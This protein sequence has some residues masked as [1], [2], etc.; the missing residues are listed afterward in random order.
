MIVM[1]VVAPETHSVSFQGARSHSLG[2]VEW[3]VAWIRISN[4]NR[5][6]CRG[7]SSTFHIISKSACTWRI[8]QPKVCLCNGLC[9]L[10]DDGWPVCTSTHKYSAS[11]GHH[12]FQSERYFSHRLWPVGGSNNLKVTFAP[13]FCLCPTKDNAASSDS[14]E[15]KTCEC[16]MGCRVILFNAIYIVEW[17]LKNQHGLEEKI[18]KLTNIWSSSNTITDQLKIVVRFLFRFKAA[19]FYL[20]W[21]FLFKW[22]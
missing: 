2:V 16:F 17:V 9:G 19:L 10:S 4:Q 1:N 18:G 11:Y 8:C 6:V 20:L 13:A 5:Q 3:F 7:I 22:F 14:I 12:S 15:A 21:Y